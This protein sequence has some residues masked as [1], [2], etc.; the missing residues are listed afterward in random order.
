MGRGYDTGSKII[1]LFRLKKK[2]INIKFQ[3]NIIHTGSD[4]KNFD[5][6]NKHSIHHFVSNDADFYTKTYKEDLFKES[7]KF[8]NEFHTK[9][10]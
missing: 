2:L 4:V 9:Y 6:Q 1:F 5:N 7:L 10:V 3:S 8:S